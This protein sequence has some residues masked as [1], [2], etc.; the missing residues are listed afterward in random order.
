MV[1]NGIPGSFFFVD[2]MATFRF[3]NKTIA[4]IHKIDEGK[5]LPL[6][7]DTSL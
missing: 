7:W 4:A 2:L 6:I 3:F 1:I 5:Y